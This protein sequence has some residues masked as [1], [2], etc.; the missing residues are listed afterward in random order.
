M[1]ILWR[2]L[3]HYFLKITTLCVLAFVAVLLTMRLDEIA[4]FAALGAPLS[5]I[6]LFTFYQIPY[7]L[8]IAIPIS[9]LIASFILIQRLSSSHELT[10]LRACGLA[11]RDILAPLLLT[12]TFL[13]VLNFWIV[14]EVATQSHLFTN[15]LKS[16]LRS[17]N[18]LLLLNNKH[19]M[20]L[21]GI[22]FDVLGPSRVGEMAIDAVLAIPNKHH[23]RLNL[24]IAQELRASSSIFTG[25]RV[26]L[27]TNLG[28]EKADEFDHLLI[29]N[30]QDTETSIP[31]FAQ[32]LQK[33]V[34]TINN[35][36]L[37]MSLLLVR[38]KEQRQ[39]LAQARADNLPSAQIKTLNYQLSRSLSD[40]SRRFSIAIAAF[41]FTLM[42]AAFGIHI[43]R[44]R[45]NKTLY[46]AIFL[47]AFYLIAFFIAKGLDQYWL[48]ATVL[49]MVPHVIL[50]TSS[51]FVLKRIT[52]GIE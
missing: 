20:R 52:K 47:T 31:D 8:P 48:T 34:W 27:L 5:Y 7:I 32:F 28:E 23:Q 43:S 30:I 22:Y 9:C 41:S 51:I 46:L 24:M 15:T 42:G 39:A 19:L 13:F 1:P 12:A 45:K 16:E 35:D 25:H 18:P 14:S 50:I 11:C 40:I 4:H 17:I 10:A 6:L 49:Y 2:Y 33:K 38:I 29:E 36:Y 37:K 44:R 26:T 21:K 3:I